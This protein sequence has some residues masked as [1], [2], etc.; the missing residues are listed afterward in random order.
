M[1]RTVATAGEALTGAPALNFH[2]KLIRLM[3]LE[4]MP[5]SPLT[6][7]LARSRRNLGQSSPGLVMFTIARATTPGVEMPVARMTAVDG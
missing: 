1:L 3:L 5:V 4:L 2:F 6:P 7:E